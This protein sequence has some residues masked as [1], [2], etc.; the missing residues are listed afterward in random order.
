VQQ[1]SSGQFTSIKNVGAILDCEFIPVGRA[2]SNSATSPI[3]PFTKLQQEKAFPGIPT[4]RALK[5]EHFIA[6]LKRLVES[7]EK[8]LYRWK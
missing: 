5:S 6:S 2:L 8:R 4:H 3:P 7:K 1:V